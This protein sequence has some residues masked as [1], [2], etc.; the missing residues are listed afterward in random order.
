MRTRVTE[1]FGIDFPICAFTH[2]RDVVAAVSSAGGLGVLGAVGHTPEQ[3]EFDLTWIRERTGG[4][5]FGVDLLIPR[6]YVGAAEGG[7]DAPGLRSML[8][9]EHRQW[10]DELLERYG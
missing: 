6:K 8:P 3:L 10:I 9:D 7:L 1:M 2:C 4:R 5:P